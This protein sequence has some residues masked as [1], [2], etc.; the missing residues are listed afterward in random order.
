MANITEKLVADNV[1]YA[2]IVFLASDPKE[3]FIAVNE[4]AYHI[5]PKSKNLSLCRYWI[6]WILEFDRICTSKKKHCKAERRS[7]IPVESKYQMD[8]IWI[9]W[10]L[11][12]GESS[13]RGHGIKKIM[14][15]LLSL[16]CIRFTPASKKRKK[17]ILYFALE[18]LIEYVDLTIP[19]QTDIQVIERVKDK[20]NIIYKQVKKNEHSP[21]TSYLFNNTI[22]SNNL[23]KTIAKLEKM[24]ELNHVFQRK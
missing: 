9:V 8:P 2:Q 19:L 4:L 5:S 15:S 11:L 12:L 13:K 16:F 18:L 22:S 1:A 20:I 17:S 23:E 21:N 10:E 24:S 14:G 7:F 6:M 3:L